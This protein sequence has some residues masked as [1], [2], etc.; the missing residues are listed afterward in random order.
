MHLDSD[1]KWNAVCEVMSALA[2]LRYSVRRVA[3][4]FAEENMMH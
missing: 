3:M 1:K 4:Y 2:E